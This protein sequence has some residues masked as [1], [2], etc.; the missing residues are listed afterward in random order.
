MAAEVWRSAHW[1]LFAVAG[2]PP[3]AAPPAVLSAVGPD[4]FTLG[5]PRAGGI[6]GARA[7]YPLLGTHPKPR[8]RARRAARVDHGGL[9]RAAGT[10]RVGIDFSLGR[11]FDHG[12]RCT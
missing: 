8:L 4:S 2:A 5:V 10:V 7:V 1:R 3:L 11:L 9:P 6:R 12:P